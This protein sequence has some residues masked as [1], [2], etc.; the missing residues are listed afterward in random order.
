MNDAQLTLILPYFNEA[1]YIAATLESLSAQ[2]ERRFRV[3]AVDNASTD[4]GPDIARQ[5]AAR[6]PW[7]DVEFVHEPQPG[8]IHALRRGTSLAQTK[9]VG[10]L[11]ADTIYPPDYVACTLAAFG[12]C[13]AAAG[14]MA[15]AAAG[16]SGPSPSLELQSRL[17]P[18]KCH[19]G[20]FGQ[21]FRRDAL[22]AAGGFDAERWGWVLEDH[23]I[24]H[25]VSR[26]GPLVYDR[27]HVCF[28]SDRRGDRTRCSWTLGERIAYKLLPAA[29]M[30]WFFYRFLA[31]RFAAR[32]LR[33]I[34]LREQV[35]HEGPTAGAPTALDA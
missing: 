19:T 16:R 15:F 30:D 9:F 23:E 35:W 32:G 34:R 26:S 4:A 1:G 12:R 11:D 21:T 33:N 18:G 3:I 14:V 17:W 8:K 13:P 24:V 22:E 29:A 7:L 5:T 31:S 27:D 10:T 2:T 25:R 6:F 20:G 28:P